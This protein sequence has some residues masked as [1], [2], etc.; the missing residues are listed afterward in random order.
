MYRIVKRRL[1]YRNTARPD[2]NE[3][4]PEKLDWAFVKWVWN[5]KLRSC[6]IT[7]GRLQ[8]AAA[9]QQVIILTSRRQVK[10]LL[11]SFAGRGRAM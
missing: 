10:E 2:M 6:M 3:G 7:L 1:M 4:C 11:R 9:H 5:Y 8:Q